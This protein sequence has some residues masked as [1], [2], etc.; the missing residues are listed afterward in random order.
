MTLKDGTTAH[1]LSYNYTDPDYGLTGIQDNNLYLIEYFAEP[2]L[3]G[4]HL[5]KFQAMLDSLKVLPQ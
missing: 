2:Q 5:P 3:Y 1:K 4:N